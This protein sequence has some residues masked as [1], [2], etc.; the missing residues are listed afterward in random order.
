VYDNGLIKI[1]ANEQI[2]TGD[3]TSLRDLTVN[4][5]HIQ[6]LGIL[7]VSGDIYL[8]QS[9]AALSAVVPEPSTALLLGMGL[10]GLA[11]ARRRR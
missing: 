8:G 11:A 2:L 5:L 4:A 3:G 9:Q 1:T 10:A 6:L 7:G